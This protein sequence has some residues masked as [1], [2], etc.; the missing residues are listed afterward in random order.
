MIVLM[1]C[2]NHPVVTRQWHFRFSFRNQSAV[3]SL[4]LLDI[5][6]TEERLERI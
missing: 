5:S 4:W 3:A 1:L 6:F 2:D